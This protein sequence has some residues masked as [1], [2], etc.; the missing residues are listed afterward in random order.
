MMQPLFDKVLVQKTDEDD[1]Q[2]LGVFY[3]PDSG[4]STYVKGKV[5]AIGTGRVDHGS[6]VPLTVKVGDI[7]LYPQVRA[8]EVTDEGN[9]DK[10][11]KLHMVSENDIIARF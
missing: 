11:V 9:T 10:D 1:T 4:K 7:V 3:V 8:V 6:V 5:L 2:K